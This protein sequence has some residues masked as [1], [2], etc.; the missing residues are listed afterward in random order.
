MQYISDKFELS[1]TDLSNHLSCDHLT[2]LNRLFAL[3]ELEKPYWNDPSLDVLIKRGQEHEAAYV[4]Y[5]GKKKLTFIDLKGQ[6]V[7]TT[8]AAMQKGI[9]VIT[10]PRLESGQWMGYADF[11]IKVSGK[12]KFGNWSY[13][14]QDTKLAQNTRAATI[15]QLCLYTDL[16]SVLQGSIPEKMYVVKPGDNFP[17]EEYRFAEFKAYYKQIKK[18]FEL[19]MDGPDLSSYPEPVEHCSICKWWRVCDKKRHDDDYLSLVAGI[20]SLHIIELQRQNILTLEQFANAKKIEKPERG[21]KETFIRKQEQAKVQL[22]GRLKNQLLHTTLD[23]ELNRGLNRLPEP[24]KGDIYFD[25]EGDAFYEDGGL[26]YILGY[27]YEINGVLAYKKLWSIN[28][29]EE[30]IAFKQFIEFVLDRWK[31]NPKMYIYHFAPY[32][33]SAIKR[34]ARVHAL[35][36]KEVDDLLRAERFIDLHAVF[37]ESLL[38]SVESYS[39]KE[40]EKFTKYTRKIDLH[41]ASIARKA[42]EVA[43]E[44]HE[45]HALSKKTLQIVEEYNEDD[46]LA[47]EALHK[48]LEDLR[49]TLLKSG[50]EIH[51]PELKTGEASENVQ[52]MDSRAQALFKALTENLPEDKSTWNEE[53]KAKWLLAHQIEYFRREDKSAWW[54]FFRVHELE[55]EDLL[56]ERKAITGLQFVEVL[57]K[58]G[59]ERNV[60]HRYR[61]PPQEV[62]IDEGDEVIEVKGDKVGSVRTISLENYIVDIKKISNTENIHPYAVHVSERVDPGSLATSLMDLAA[63]IDEYG[64]AHAWPYHA[65]KD[66]LMKR[67]PQLTGGKEGAYLLPDEDPVDGAVRIA[68]A[69]DRSVLALQGPPGAG[70]T[71]TGATMIVELAK[72]GKK[73]G[74]TAVSHKVIRN[75]TLACI[76]RGHELNT[77]LSFTH[78]VSEKSEDVADEI[79]EVTKSDQVRAALNEG[80][81][82]CGTAWLWAEP[83]SREVL[84]YLFVDEAGQMSLSQVL[85]ASRAT[86]NLILLGDPQQLEQPQ[87]GTHPEGSDVAALTYLLNGHPTMPEGMGL[88]LEVTRRLHPNICNFTSEIFY[89]GRLTS[90]PGLENQVISGGTPFDGAG[91]FYVPVDHRGNHDNSPEEVQAVAEIIS[92]LLATGKWTNAKGETKPLTKKDILIVAPYNA[93]V[94]VLTKAEPEMRIGTVDKFQGQEAPIVIYSMTTSTVQDAPRGMSFLF[95]PNRFNVATSRAKST[96]I[97]VAS[98]RLLEPECNTIDQMRWA[99]A[100]CSFKELAS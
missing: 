36:E 23:F 73:I 48:W 53:Q 4:E 56:D 61:Y 57:P 13:E 50:K 3:G 88:F 82:A 67:K 47:T 19:I 52:Q 32:E 41:D 33:P 78:K 49:T 45:I 35:Y 86:K 60:T 74:I 38:A 85:A 71:Y 63:A 42:V 25:I 43:L 9:D 37:K 39:L 54:E 5:L 6:P 26:E 10:Q 94:A 87:R 92:R 51:R 14:V 69:L 22:E 76:E 65:S 98:N 59:K 34:L 58:V 7:A 31:T 40:L 27:A 28:R 16:L 72:A 66:L 79:V 8:I 100:L 70:K 91:L 21:N 96:C 90:L 29:M 99:N 81:I 77:N 24:N 11:L 97:L 44:L 17:V 62:S 80:K 83:D 84:D 55:H 12:S 64:L 93:Q 68:S 46:C 1:A 30:K 15:I 2:Q 89:E 18:N 20:R 95:N 75:L